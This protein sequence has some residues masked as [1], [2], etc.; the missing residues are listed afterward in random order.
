M[1][2]SPDRASGNSAH[3][4]APQKR[5]TCSEVGS[6]GHRLKT[7]FVVQAAEHLFGDDTVAVADP[8]ATRR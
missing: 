2:G 1:F 4:C 3:A 5:S 7:I 8:M 6:C